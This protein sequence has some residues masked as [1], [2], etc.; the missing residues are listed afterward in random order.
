MIKSGQDIGGRQFVEIMR[1]IFLVVVIVIISFSVYSYIVKKNK[2]GYLENQL[3]VVRALYGKDCLLYENERVN[4]GV[5]DLSKIENSQK[6]FLGRD[7]GFLASITDKEGKEVKNFIV[8]KDI[9]DLRFGCNVARKGFYC[10]TQ[11]VFVRYYDGAEIK[12]GFLELNM[13]RYNE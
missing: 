10:D 13:V 4:V 3:L 12:P 11:K 2:T 5:I 6:C 9:A 8:N 7:F 1:L